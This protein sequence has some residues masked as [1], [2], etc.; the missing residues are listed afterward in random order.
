M[1]RTG[2]IILINIGLVLGQQTA[3][4]KLVGAINKVLIN[5]ASDWITNCILEIDFARGV[6]MHIW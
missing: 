4:G 3:C 5:V 2:G 6:S 1:K